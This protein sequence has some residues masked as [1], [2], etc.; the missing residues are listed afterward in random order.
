MSAPHYYGEAQPPSYSTRPNS[1]AEDANNN[2]NNQVR[3]AEE[4]RNGR[5]SPDFVESLF[6]VNPLL[7]RLVHQ[8]ART[9]TA[10]VQQPNPYP[11]RAR[12]HVRSRLR[13]R[14]TRKT[15][16]SKGMWLSSVQLESENRYRC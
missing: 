13:M 11:V 7:P 2:N 5:R 1:I 3:D 16:R 15:S 4:G 8:G 10:E 9:A 14:L 12:V 6:D